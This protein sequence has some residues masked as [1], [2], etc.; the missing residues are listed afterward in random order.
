MLETHVGHVRRLARVAPN[1]VELT[2]G[3]LDGAVGDLG[4]DEFWYLMAANPAAPRAIADGFTIGDLDRFDDSTR[5]VAAYYT[6]RRRRHGEIDFWILMHGHS[7]GFAEW[8]AKAQVGDPVAAWGP[9]I[10]YD[11]PA[12]LSGRLLVCDETGLAA[13]AAILERTPLGSPVTVVVEVI[14]A[15]HRVPFVCRGEVDVIWVERRGTAPGTS[16]LLLDAVRSLDLDVSRLYAFGAGESHEV[17]AIRRHL[18]HDRGM[19]CDAVS[20]T[21]YWRRS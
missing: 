17:S 13:V 19:S 12:E 9:R 1:I 16:G 4:G 5:P 15:D 11:P 2:L 20:M 3:G 6:R 8:V 14:D 18:R 21:G 7:G 10:V